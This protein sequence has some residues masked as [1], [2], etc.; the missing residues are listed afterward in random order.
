MTEVIGHRQ[1]L[2]APTGTQAIA[3][4]IHTPHLIDRAGQLQRH[5]LG[6]R[7]LDLLA[8]AHGQVGRAVQPVDLLVVHAGVL[9]AQQVVDASI[10]EA[11][12]RACAISTMLAQIASVDHHGDCCAL[13]LR[14]PTS[15]S[16][17]RFHFPQDA[18]ARTSRH[19]P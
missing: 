2:D 8:L 6:R 10:A 16:I 13:G 9:R 7:T 12:T 14:R 3:D 19:A 4:E 1:A 11:P 5:A 17:P 18:P 15:L